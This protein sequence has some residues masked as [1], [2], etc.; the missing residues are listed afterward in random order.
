MNENEMAQDDEISLFDLWEKL[1]DGWLAVVGGTVLGIAGA[2]LAI[3]LIPPKYEAVA[4]VQVGQVG[5][6]GQ[7]VALGEMQRNRSVQLA[8]PVESAVQAVE[9]MKITAFQSRVSER[10]GVVGQL[11]PQVIKATVTEQFPLIEL[12]VIGSNPEYL[13]KIAGAAI[14]E[15]A[16]SEE[17]L[18]QPQIEL[19][20]GELRIAEEKQ[21]KLNQE[22]GDLVKLNVIG[23]S[24]EGRA[25]QPVILTALRVQKEQELAGQ[26]QL[27]LA[28]QAALARTRPAQALEAISVG[29]TPVSPKKNLLLA[30]G[31]IGG[32]L[33]GMLWVFIA[34]A[35]RRA[36]RVRAGSRA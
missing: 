29:Q 25:N 15:L 32:L 9:R 20:R 12:K 28:T 21:A 36:K 22:I 17:S 23:A 33:A 8:Q 2:V 7:I 27:I 24:N 13:H 34:D 26:S 11:I 6:V 14:A 1:R 16:V 10:A 31:A 5:Q 3:F 35:W 30:L 19:L 18:V 4:V